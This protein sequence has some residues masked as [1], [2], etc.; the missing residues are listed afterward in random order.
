MGHDI[1]GY[2]MSGKEI[3]Y[4]R[5]NMGNYNATILYDLFDANDYYTGVSGTGDSSTFS[6]EQCEMAM[7]KFSHLYNR[8]ITNYSNNSALIPWDLKQIQTFVNNC[9]ATAIKEGNV[10][11]FFG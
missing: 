11:V 4:A 7:N 8:Y 10:K 1:L 5:F 3:A 2:N 6:L 9:L